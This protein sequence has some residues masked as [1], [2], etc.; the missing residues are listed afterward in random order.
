MAEKTVK[1]VE[2]VQVSAAEEVD[3]L[4]KKGQ[5]ALEKFLQLDQ[6]AVD[7]IVAKC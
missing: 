5:V 7:F 1:A 3:A 4:V 6:E 2:E